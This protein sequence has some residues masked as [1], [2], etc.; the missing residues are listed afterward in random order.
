MTNVA[1]H[2]QASTLGVMINAGRDRL[3]IDVS[4]DGVGLHQS[5]RRSG[6]ANL[7]DRAHRRGGT[8]SGEPGARTSSAAMVDS[9]VAGPAFRPS[10][11]DRSTLAGRVSERRGL[12]TPI[13]QEAQP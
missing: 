7:S 12:V 9:A 1:R 13:R 6:L 11:V 5:A 2:A 10:I 3:T 4:D 8:L